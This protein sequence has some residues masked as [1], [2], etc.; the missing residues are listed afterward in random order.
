MKYDDGGKP[1]YDPHDLCRCGHELQDHDE[2][3][4]CLVEDCTCDAFGDRDQEV[5]S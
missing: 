2:D 4:A 3:L 5:A 1:D